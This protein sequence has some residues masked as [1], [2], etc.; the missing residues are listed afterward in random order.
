MPSKRW[1]LANSES[2]KRLLA[3]KR[4]MTVPSAYTGTTAKTLIRNTQHRWVQLLQLDLMEI[5]IWSRTISGSDYCIDF[6]YWLQN[7]KTLTQTKIPAWAW[8][9]C[10]YKCRQA[11]FFSSLTDMKLNKEAFLWMKYRG[12]FHLCTLHIISFQRV[13]F[14]IFYYVFFISIMHVN[15]H[16]Y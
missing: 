9:E 6:P 11:G 14:F 7:G 12:H 8:D 3:W 5:W 13:I 10:C 1:I 4:K 15:F 2:L 16:K